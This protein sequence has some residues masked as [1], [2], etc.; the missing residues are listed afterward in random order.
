M[1][2]KV[3]AGTRHALTLH[4]LSNHTGRSKHMKMNKR[5]VALVVGVVLLVAVPGCDSAQESDIVTLPVQE[6]FTLE[7]NGAAL[8]PVKQANV[9]SAP[10][11]LSGNLSGFSKEAIITGGIARV[12][13]ERVQPP[14][15]TL[16]DIMDGQLTVY[17]EGTGAGRAV[18]IGQIDSV[19]DVTSLSIPIAIDGQIAP[20]LKA[21]EYRVALKFTPAETTPEATIRLRV[22][23]DF[24]VTFEGP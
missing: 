3:Y 22:E 2:R 7:F 14:G 1:T 15:A 23:V 12:Q 20:L 10:E 18:Q 8:D 4:V 5:L 16:S 11:T 21:P 17:L 24:E 9:H 19:T 13:V 6:S